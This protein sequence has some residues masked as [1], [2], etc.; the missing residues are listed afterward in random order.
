MLHVDDYLTFKKK[1]T[2]VTNRVIDN[3]NNVPHAE[4]MENKDV[5]WWLLFLRYT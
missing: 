2:K 3:N 1:K 5:L 4:N